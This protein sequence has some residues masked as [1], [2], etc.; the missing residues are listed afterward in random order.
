MADFVSF[1]PIAVTQCDDN[2]QIAKLESFDLVSMAFVIIPDLQDHFMIYLTNM[3][4]SQ[5]SVSS[6]QKNL[7]KLFFDEFKSEIKKY[8]KFPKWHNIKYHG[9]ILCF[10]TENCKHNQP[11][12]K[13]PNIIACLMFNSQMW[14]CA[15]INFKYEMYEEK[16]AREGT[17]DWMLENNEEFSSIVTKYMKNFAMENLLTEDSQTYIEKLN[18]LKQILQEKF[19]KF[20]SNQESEHYEFCNDEYYFNTIKYELCSECGYYRKRVWI[21]F[22]TEYIDE[23]YSRFRSVDYVG[24]SDDDMNDDMN[25]EKELRRDTFVRNTTNKLKDKRRHLRNKGF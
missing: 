10:C 9:E 7:Q 24:A 6:H 21:D 2:I 13:C 22:F 23:D 19:N 16:L 12:T 25:D 20:I 11:H 17:F 8:E 18:H 5:E 15:F 1:S 4:V 14:D 3:G